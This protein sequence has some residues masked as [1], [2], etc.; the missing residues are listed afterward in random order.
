MTS[1]ASS[2]GDAPPPRRR[3]AIWGREIPRRNQKFIGREK[4][5][6]DLRT[7]LVADST[8]LIGQPEQTQTGQ[9]VQA[10]YG[11]GGVGKTELATEYAHRY[12][13]EYD[14]VWWIR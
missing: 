4:E 3:H 14:L 12:R 6:T 9:P 13:S 8:A 10:V 11:L 1:P 5:L 7:F 2:E